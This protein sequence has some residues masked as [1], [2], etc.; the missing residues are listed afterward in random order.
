M[1]PV[2]TLPADAKVS[3]PGVY[4]I[5]I[6]LYHGDCCTG[7][8]ISSSGLRKIELQ[9]PAHYFVDSYL[10]PLRVANDPSVAL[11]F[12]QAA[13][14]LLLGEG[15]FRERFAV[16]P[17]DFPD[18]RT[19]AAREWRDAQR[20]AGKTVLTPEQVLHIK[21]IAASLARHPLIKAGLLQGEVERSLLWRDHTG[22]WLKSRPDVL[23]VS[24]GVVV[25]LKT[26]DDAAP[27]AMERAILD[28]GYAMQGALTGMALKAVC[29]IEMAAFVLVAVEKVPPYAVSIIE[30]DGVWLDYARRQIRR[31]IDT[32]AKCLKTGEWPAFEGEAKA[33]IPEWLRKRLDA[34]SDC[35]LLPVEDAA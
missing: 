32:F 22:V 7:P 30:V 11:D 33:Y 29:G 20:D 5:D 8:S 14:T 6:E 27:R 26:A 17:D 34:E 9:S 15:G 19:K 13:H 2:R 31:G 24:D 25:D 16:R 35:G 18:Y 4:A 1:I 3:E 23:P 10:N 12:G 28:R 21:G